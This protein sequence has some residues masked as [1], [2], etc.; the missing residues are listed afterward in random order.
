M[1]MYGL[2]YVKCTDGIAIYENTMEC[3]VVNSDI[4]KIINQAICIIGKHNVYDLDESPFL[5]NKKA[6][7]HN[8]RIFHVDNIRTHKIRGLLGKCSA[9][10]I[11]EIDYDIVLKKIYQLTNLNI[12]IKRIHDVVKYLTFCKK[13]DNIDELTKAMFIHHDKNKFN[14]LISKSENYIDRFLPT[15]VSPMIILN[16]PVD[17]DLEMEYNWTIKKCLV[18][19]LETKNYYVGVILTSREGGVPFKINSSNINEAKYELVIFNKKFI[20]GIISGIKQMENFQT[21]DK[22]SIIKN[23]VKNLNLKSI[24]GN[25]Y[26]SLAKFHVTNYLYDYF[27]VDE[28]N[29]NTKSINRLYYMSYN[30]VK[31]FSHEHEL[32]KIL[33]QDRPNYIDNDFDDSSF[34]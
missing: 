10:I 31:E 15:H 8:L 22:Y 30:F 13:Y 26:L 33:Y 34:D 3:L 1:N 25:K 17:K 4:Y 14:E 12:H 21:N 6:T 19:Y 28:A 9:R 32:N 18:N 20:D 2:C 5:L 29:F 16:I 11:R 7:T 23:Y 27:R 24:M